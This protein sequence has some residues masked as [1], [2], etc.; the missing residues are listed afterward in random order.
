MENQTGSKM[1][2]KIAI[3]TGA[4]TGIG[5]AI[6]GG[7]L[8]NGYKVALLGRRAAVPLPQAAAKRL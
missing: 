8:K 5:K 2:S 6:A 3:V 7:L 1:A 4:G